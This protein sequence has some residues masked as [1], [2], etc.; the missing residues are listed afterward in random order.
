MET[1][2][3]LSGIKN[4]V[5]TLTGASRPERFKDFNLGTAV[6]AANVLDEG[7]YV[8]MNGRVYPWGKV[9]RD[10]ETGNFVEKL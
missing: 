9:E 6:G 8:A 4:K 2:G 5:I 7:V 3:E 1:A 10:K